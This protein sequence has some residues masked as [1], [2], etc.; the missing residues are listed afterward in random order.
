MGAGQNFLSGN[1]IFLKHLS[2][3]IQF[4]LQKKCQGNYMLS[5]LLLFIN[6]RLL[7]IQT[8]FLEFQFNLL[9]IG[10]LPYLIKFM[11]I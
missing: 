11:D 5:M 10:N 8:I 6:I 4:Y 2:E 7:S 1:M 9:N 3:Y